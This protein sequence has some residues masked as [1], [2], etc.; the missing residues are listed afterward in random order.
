MSHLLSTA[1]VSPRDRLS[2]WVDAVCSTF[3]QLDCE[4][5]GHGGLL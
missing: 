5:P 3:V 2:Y 1:T 4:V